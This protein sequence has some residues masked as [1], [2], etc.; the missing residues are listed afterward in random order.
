MS[1]TVETSVVNSTAYGLLLFPSF[2]LVHKQLQ[3]YNFYKSPATTK[4]NFSRHNA[5]AHVEIGVTTMLS[6]VKY[7]I[8]RSK[9]TKLMETEGSH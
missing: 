2:L 5:I 7:Q 9:L 6:T 3:K 1:S 8:I 4:I